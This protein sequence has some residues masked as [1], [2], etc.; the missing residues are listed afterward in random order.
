MLGDGGQFR[1]QGVEDPVELGVHTRGVGL[2]IDKVQQRPP[3]RLSALRGRGHQVRS[4]VGATPPPRRPGQR[5]LDRRDEFGVSVAGHERNSGEVGAVRSRKNPSQPAPSSALVTCTPR[6]SWCPS[7]LTP[8]ALADLEHERV[9]GEEGARVGVEG[10]PRNS[11][12]VASSSADTTLTGDYDNL[13]MPSAS[14]S[15]SI[16][17]VGMPSRS[18]VATTV[19]RARS[20]RRRS[21]SQSG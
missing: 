3:P 6:I 14:T 10:R 8:A 15:F 21:S 16:C 18:Q 17:C 11:A 12:T 20:A 7:A 13:V 19:V 9:R 4:V 5:G 2:V 1:G